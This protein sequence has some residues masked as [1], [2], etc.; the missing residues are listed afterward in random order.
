MLRLLLLALAIAIF[1]WLLARIMPKF[2]GLLMRAGQNPMLRSFAF[3]AIYRLIRLL[4]F[5]R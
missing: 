1:V 2:R 3:T 4:I 5:R